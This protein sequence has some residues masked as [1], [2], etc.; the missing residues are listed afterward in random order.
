MYVQ[1]EGNPLINKLEEVIES[2]GGYELLAIAIERE[3]YGY[4]YGRERDEGPKVLSEHVDEIQD[5]RNFYY[6]PKVAKRN[7]RKFMTVKKRHI[8]KRGRAGDY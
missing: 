4:D 3:W 5:R 7:Q 1:L 2:Y 8:Q 6:R